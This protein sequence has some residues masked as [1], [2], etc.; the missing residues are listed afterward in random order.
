ME[1][2]TDEIEM[3]RNKAVVWAYYAGAQR[4]DI[5]GYGEF[6]HADF[7]LQAPSYL[8]WGGSYRGADQFLHVV[9]PQVGQ[10]LDFSRFSFDSITAEEDRVVALINVGVMHRD[11]MLKVSEHWVVNQEKALSLW[12]AYYE[13]QELLEQLG[14]ALH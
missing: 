5:S 7:L 12:V 14:V 10:A 9:L 3:A 11:A 2:T 6:L 4:G 8:P 1:A 13:P